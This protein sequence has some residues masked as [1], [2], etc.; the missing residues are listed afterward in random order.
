[1]IR[2]EAMRLGLDWSEAQIQ[3]VSDLYEDFKEIR[4]DGVGREYATIY[5]P[6]TNTQREIFIGFRGEGNE[7]YEALPFRVKAT[8][9]TYIMPMG[10][11][12]DE[13]GRVDLSRTRP[14]Q[15]VGNI[16]ESDLARIKKQMIERQD[17][18]FQ[19]SQLL[20]DAVPQNATGPEEVLKNLATHS[21]GTFG[22]DWANYFKTEE[23]ILRIKDWARTYIAANA[24]SDRYA[25]GEQQIL[26]EIVSGDPAFFEN[27]EA[28]GRRLQTIMTGMI[29]DNEF[30][31]AL[32]EGRAPARLEYLA[33]GTKSDPLDYSKDSVR[34]LLSVA[35]EQGR[36]GSWNAKLTPQDATVVD[37]GRI[38]EDGTLETYEE[39]MSA[40]EAGQRAGADKYKNFVENNNP[41][42]AEII[43]KDLKTEHPNLL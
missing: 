12:I 15:D 36:E 20:A 6:R 7:D 14:V 40:F 22:A 28:F 13:N 5:D 32:M 23:N 10:A 30:D 8:D 38:K 26:N 33:S 2:Q 37:F 41:V 9:P 17:S 1:M 18:M 11:T 31:Q 27:P 24:L 21:L 25:M 34:R 4:V 16:S 3:S 29:N 19:L 43:L 39:I 42:F 35:S